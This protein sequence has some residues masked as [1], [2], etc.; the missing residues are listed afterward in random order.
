MKGTKQTFI[1]SLNRVLRVCH[2]VWPLFAHSLLLLPAIPSKHLSI[3]KCVL[4]AIRPWLPT[5]TAA[6]TK[7]K[8]EENCSLV[9]VTR[10]IAALKTDRLVVG[11]HTRVRTI[12]QAYMDQQI[13]A[14]GNYSN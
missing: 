11:M 2:E 3:I 5:S 6:A 12:Y 7:A 14:A 9:R 8:H 10:R 13:W 4:S 1:R